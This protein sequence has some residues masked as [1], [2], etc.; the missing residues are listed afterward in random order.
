MRL[1]RP[2]AAGLACLALAAAAT[3]RAE[4]P[5]SALRLI[6]AEA[7]LLVEVRQPRQLVEALTN[8][9]LLRQ[10]RQFSAFQEQLDSTRARRFFQLVAYFEKELGAKWPELLDRLAGGGAAVGLKFEPNPAPALLV[11]QGK[12]EALTGKFVKLLLDV[13]EQEL[14]RLEAK[15][16]PV[17]GTYHGVET[18]HLGEQ[19]HLAVAG[20]AILVSNNANALERG[21]DLHLGR[22]TKSLAQ[23]G[24]V[25]ESLKLLPKDPLVN[26]WVNMESV[27]QTPGGK[28][29]YKKPREGPVTV[30]LGDIIDIL[31]RSPYAAA[32]LA[33]EKD[34]VLI[35]ARAPRGRDG[36][37]IELPLHLPP[38]GQP[39]S[40][41]LLQPKGVIYSDS[42]YID[43]A[44]IW[45][46]R[47]YLFGEKQAKAL[48]EFDRTSARF[49]VGTKMSQLLTQAGPYFRTVVV[50]QPAVPYKTKPKFALPAFALIGELREPEAFAKSLDAVFRAAALLAGFQVKLTLVEDKHGEVPIVGWRFAEGAEQKGD[51]NDLRFNFSPC[52]CRVG[53]QYV[54]CSTLELCHEL[55][56]LLEKEA[57]GKPTGEP[58]KSR[59]RLY[60]AGAADILHVFEDQ[61]VTQAIL[62][63]ALSEDEARSQIKAL[64]ALVRGLGQL[65]IDINCTDEEFHYDIRVKETP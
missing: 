23:T 9:D 43:V 41:P 25:A 54:V 59:A 51:P 46:D 20:A 12:E 3:A 4:V 53:N 17:K 10:L 19:L 50:N 1:Y 64:V 22:A 52:F 35:T 18:V 8:L 39:G 15:E 36:M 45:T 49:L 63:Q 24:S 7:D 11:V 40:R 62:A 57:K 65:A 16:R 13:T 34:G 26:L 42:Y 31:N 27:R 32:A 30:A 55:V 2:L 33:R 6:P 56:D 37:G 14:S 38:P 28:E 60:S 44:R 47:G 48:E 21:L 5:P 61:L 58:A 29:F